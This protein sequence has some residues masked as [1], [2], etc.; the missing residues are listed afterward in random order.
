MDKVNK[1]VDEVKAQMQKNV[2][3]VMN[4]GENLSNLEKQSEKMKQSGDKFSTNTK[5]VTKMFEWKNRKWTIILVV[6][7]V[8]LLGG[9]GGF[10]YYMFAPKHK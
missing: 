4:R 2:T 1:Q 5:R 7:I 8:I 6:G 3:M 10:L 9:L